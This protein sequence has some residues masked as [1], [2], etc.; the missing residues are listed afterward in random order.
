MYQIVL[1][2]ACGMY[3][4]WMGVNSISDSGAGYFD[5]PDGDGLVNLMEYVLGGDSHS[6]TNQGFVDIIQIRTGASGLEYIYPARND[7]ATRGLDY[8]LESCGDLVNGGWTNGS[9]PLLGTGPL[10]AEFNAVTNQV[11]SDDIRG[12]IRLKVNIQ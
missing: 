8:R 2:P 10:D 9:F 12:F 6:A 3:R 11:P 1:S 4:D 5:D 7:A